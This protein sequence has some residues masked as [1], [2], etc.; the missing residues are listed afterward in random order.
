RPVEGLDPEVAALVLGREG[1]GGVHAGA[2]D[3]VR[4]GGEDRLA[5]VL[6]AG[7]GDALAVLT[8]LH[9]AV[10]ADGELRALLDVARHEGLVVEGRPNRGLGDGAGGHARL[11][12]R[13][14]RDVDL[15]LE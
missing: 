1:V 11:S 8:A 4:T 9:G 6:E 2:V 15:L 12:L 5:G 3:R 10:Q 7:G 13:L 14:A